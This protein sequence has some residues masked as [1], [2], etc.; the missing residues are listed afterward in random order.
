MG[1]NIRICTYAYSM[2]EGI[3]PSLTTYVQKGRHHFLFFNMK[4]TPAGEAD[5]IWKHLDREEIKNGMICRGSDG[6]H[7]GKY[8]KVEYL[9]KK[10]MTVRF[11]KKSGSYNVWK[12]SVAIPKFEFW[13]AKEEIKTIESPTKR[14]TN[15]SGKVSIKTLQNINS[16]EDI[17]DMG[18][19]SIT[20]QIIGIR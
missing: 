8:A 12:D 2:Y 17:N 10:N 5:G 6:A 1:Q 3:I 14:L 15:E 19:L 16:L 18:I 13:I 7:Q 11:R 20:L 4:W 9:T